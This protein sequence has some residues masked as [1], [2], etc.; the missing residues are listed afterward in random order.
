M[1]KLN[2]DKKIGI[3]MLEH[4]RTKQEFWGGVSNMLGNWLEARQKL[5]VEYAALCQNIQKSKTPALKARLRHFC[6]TLVDYTSSAHFEI[7]TQLNRESEQFN[8]LEALKIGKNLCL[9]LDHCTDLVLKFDQRYCDFEHME[10]LVDDLSQLG[11]H[12]E[13][14][15][16][17]EDTM[18]NIMHNSHEEQAA[19]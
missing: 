13:Q 3:A 8:D 7:Y 4:C 2:E 14:R 6:Q 18:I 11:L 9:Q 5:L 17:V 10:H 16:F 15:F 1:F 12:L 19:A